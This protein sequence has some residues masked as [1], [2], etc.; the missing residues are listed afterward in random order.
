VSYRQIL[1]AQLST[2]EG[3]RQKPYRDTVGKLTIGVGRNLDDIGVNDAEISLMLDNDIAR[4]EAAAYRLVPTFEDL[5]D[6]RKAV[7][8]NMAF[9]L[10]ERTLGGFHDTLQAI[11]EQRWE[12]AA[13]HM[14]ESHWASQVGARAQRLAQAMRDG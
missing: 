1:K 10:G 8:V 14:L 2:D 3:Y 9:N 11:A 7:I 4:A 12:D 13:D 6:V 5:S